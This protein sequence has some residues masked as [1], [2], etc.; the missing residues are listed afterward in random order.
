MGYTSQ[1]GDI[2]ITSALTR[3]E[4]RATLYHELLHSKLTPKLYA[5]RSLR[6]TISGYAN[7]HL[8]RYLEEALCETYALLR[9]NGFSKQM[10]LEGI[11]FP[12]VADY[13]TVAAL[14]MEAKGLPLG[15]VVVGGM[16]YNVFYG[17]GR[18]DDL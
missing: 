1:W 12:I 14:G 16:I 4:Q 2:H 17:T 13:T 9:A 7:S 3:A 8:L 18:P 5:L 10:L 6:V 11:R 15:P